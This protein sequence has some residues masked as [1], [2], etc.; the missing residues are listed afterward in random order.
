MFPV[1]DRGSRETFI[2][3]SV[4]CPLGVLDRSRWVERYACDE[5]C[6]GPTAIGPDPS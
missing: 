2:S 3:L 1:G 4:G 6:R 5:G